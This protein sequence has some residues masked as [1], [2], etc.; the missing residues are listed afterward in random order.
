MSLLYTNNRE[1]DLVNMIAAEV[2]L[3][4]Q[5]RPCFGKILWAKALAQVLIGFW[6]GARWLHER[7]QADGTLH[8]QAY[9]GGRP[10]PRF[11]KDLGE[12]HGRRQDHRCSPGQEP[13][14]CAR[15]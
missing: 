3:T 7:N 1:N 10:L 2:S 9:Q 5:D 8:L 4:P 15:K 12:G 13:Q 14:G 11:G 6:L